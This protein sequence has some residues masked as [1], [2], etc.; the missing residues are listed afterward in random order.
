MLILVVLGCFDSYKIDYSPRN[1]SRFFFGISSKLRLL[2]S[3]VQPR[4]LKGR[5]DNLAVKRGLDSPTC[6]SWEAMKMQAV[7]NLAMDKTH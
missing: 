6:A 4:R 3:S 1:F 7:G 2:Q 5:H